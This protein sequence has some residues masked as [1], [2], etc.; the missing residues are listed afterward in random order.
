MRFVQDGTKI[1]DIFFSENLN[2]TIS[3]RYIPICED[4]FSKHDL[5]IQ[6][7]KLVYTDN[8]PC[9]VENIFLLFG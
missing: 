2:R 4:F 5:E 8:A 7:I 1:E 3:K 6:I 9:Y